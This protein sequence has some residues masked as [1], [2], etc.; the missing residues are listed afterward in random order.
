[1][2]TNKTC[3]IIPCY[4]EE[5]RLPVEDFK[6]FIAKNNIH[7]CFVNDG[8]KDATLSLLQKIQEL[9]PEKIHIKDVQPNAGKANAVRE[10]I[11]SVYHKYDYIGYFDAD[12]ATPLY[13]IG[14]LLS[15][16]KKNEGVKLAFGSRILTVNSQIERKAYR[17]YFGRIIATC[18]SVILQLNIYDTQCGA[19]LF[20]KDI[21]EICFEKPFISRWLFDVEIFKRIKSVYKSE[22]NIRIKEMPLQQW[23]DV[24]ES[25]ITFFDMLKVPIELIKINFSKE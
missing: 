17:H 20:S 8:S 4:N 6:D 5:N 19:K 3:I 25:K 11:L 18:I 13:E 2:E 1:M 7:F 24:N 14:N 23:I 16:F 22:T 12:L 15:E 21:I 10:G 9:F